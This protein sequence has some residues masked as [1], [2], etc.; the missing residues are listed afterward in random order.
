MTPSA[1]TKAAAVVAVLGIAAAIVVG[2]LTPEVGP[3]ARS[4]R[5]GWDGGKPADVACMETAALTSPRTRALFGLDADG[6]DQYV[7]VRICGVPTDGGQPELPAGMVPVT[8][9][10]RTAA[11]GDYQLEAWMDGAGFPCACSTGADCE[12][13]VSDGGWEAALLGVTF[14]DGA[15]RGTGCYRKTCVE[16]FGTSSWPPACPGGP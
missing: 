5:I 1:A 8:P 3:G 15:W 4:L 11:T 13:V 16:L 10:E 12:A 14:N 6:G 9:T 7:Y 2:T